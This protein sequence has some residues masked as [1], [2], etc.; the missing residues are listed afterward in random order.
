M[1]RNSIERF[2]EQLISDA[3][4]D[5]KHFSQLCYKIRTE[6]NAELEWKFMLLVKTFK[7]IHKDKEIPKLNSTF[8]FIVSPNYDDDQKKPPL[9]HGR[10]HAA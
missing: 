8:L 9:H 5:P 10:S 7:S 4:L 2:C 6:I 3:E 1:L